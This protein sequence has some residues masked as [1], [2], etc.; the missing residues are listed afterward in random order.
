MFTGCLF[1]RSLSALGEH[2]RP[3]SF[4][5]FF[6]EALLF[7][8]IG[9]TITPKMEIN[10]KL[11]SDHPSEAIDMKTNLFAGDRSESDWYLKI[12]RENPKHGHPNK[13]GGPKKLN[14]Q[15]S[16]TGNDGR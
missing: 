11:R 9:S 2:F 14:L 10:V 12:A 3:F 8:P 6:P 4:L 1:E 7:L 16:E 15:S 5:L 13:I